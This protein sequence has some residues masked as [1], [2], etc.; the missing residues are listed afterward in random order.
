MAPLTQPVTDQQRPSEPRGEQTIEDAPQ[1]LPPA[2]LA[3]LTHVKAQLLAEEQEYGLDLATL[4]I[5]REYAT[6]YR[7]I[8]AALVTPV[9]REAA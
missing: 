8:V 3:Y 6:G 9:R 7:R 4:A 2:A 5:G 1:S